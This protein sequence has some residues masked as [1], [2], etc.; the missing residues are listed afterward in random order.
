MQVRFLAEPARADEIA[1]NP[2]PI[3]TDAAEEAGLV[4]AAV[5]EIDWEDELRVAI[6]ERASLSPDALT[7]MEANLRFAGRRERGQQGLRP[8]FGVAEL[9]L[10]APQCHRRAR[11]A[12]RST[13]SRSGPQFNW[14][15]T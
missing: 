14:R 1:A 6:E 9:D 13:A 12:L 15:R 10:L 11:R 4:T 7:G 2:S 8:A 5:D 3:D